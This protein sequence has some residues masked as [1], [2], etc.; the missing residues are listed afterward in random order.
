MFTFGWGEI[1]LIF[2]VVIVVVGPKDIPNFIR[3]IG[4]ITKTIKKVSRE[5]KTSLNEIT[6]EKEIKDFKKSISDVKNL[7][8]EFDIKNNLK[9][10]IETIK[11]TASVVEKNV[12][13]INKIKNK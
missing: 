4:K 11:E 10:E 12:S 9:D 7:K 6:D 1:L 3:Q 13:D 8:K 2:V 5:F